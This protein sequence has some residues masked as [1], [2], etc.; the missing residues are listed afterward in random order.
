[1][2]LAGFKPVIPA[3]ERPQTHALDCLATGIGHLI[4]E[5]TYFIKQVG[6]CRVHCLPNF[7]ILLIFFV[8][9]E[10]NEILKERHDVLF[11]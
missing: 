2:P 1:M 11:S 6:Y 9:S 3:S 5:D 10:V 7:L 4:M 8:H